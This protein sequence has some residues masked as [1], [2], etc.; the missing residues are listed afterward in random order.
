M[1]KGD[2]VLYISRE[3]RWD[4]L[5]LTFQFQLIYA[6]N[7]RRTLKLCR[8]G[9]AGELWKCNLSKE[10]TALSKEITLRQNN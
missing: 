9:D 7:H 3:Y 5:K 10:L 6:A 4:L 2:S 8:L 1:G